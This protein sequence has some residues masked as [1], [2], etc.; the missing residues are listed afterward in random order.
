MVDAAPTY[1]LMTA[2]SQLLS[3]L[4]H[5]QPDT[6]TLLKTILVKIIRN[7]PYQTL[8]MTMAVNNVSSFLKI[9]LK[10]IIFKFIHVKIVKL[11]SVL[12]DSVC[13]Q[14]SQKPVPANIQE[15]GKCETRLKSDDKGLQGLIG[16][17]YRFFRK[18]N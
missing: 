13:K 10:S 2:F 5:T 4:C 17:S 14:S 3:R 9:K 15:C 1:V 7:H 8:W 12:F 6:W 18:S 16:N 11:Q